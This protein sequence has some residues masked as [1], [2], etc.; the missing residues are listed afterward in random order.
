MLNPAKLRVVNILSTIVILTAC[1]GPKHKAPLTDLQQPPSY[2]ITSH[3][4]ASNE[5]LYSIAWRYGLDVR[6]L[7]STNDLGAPY[8]LRPGQRL[9]L[10]TRSQPT[11]KMK[12]TPKNRS[13]DQRSKNKP[14]A[15]P[16]RKQTSTQKHKLSWRWPASGTLLAKFGDRQALSK[17]IDIAAKKGEPV[18]AAESGSVVYAG[19]GLR[20]YGNLLIIKH[21]YN[22]L[23]AYAHNQKILVGEGDSVKAGQKIAEIGSSGTD[24]NKLHFEIRQDGNPVDPLQHLPRRPK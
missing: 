11:H 13:V 6:D 19:D 17:G 12:K 9:N 1:S 2:K 24:R 20:G 15:T 18:F 10:D 21:E 3:T 4:V 5:T 22:F 16:P 7:A 8:L 14:L 23:S